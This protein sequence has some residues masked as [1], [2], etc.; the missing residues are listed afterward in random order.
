MVP[1]YSLWVVMLKHIALM[2]T[3]QL[4]RSSHVL[5]QLSS[6]NMLSHHNLKPLY[7]SNRQI[8]L[9]ILSLIRFNWQG[10]HTTTT[11]CSSPFVSSDNHSFILILSSKW[12]CHFTVDH[13]VLR[14]ELSH[15]T[16]A[17]CFHPIMEANNQTLRSHHP[18]IFIHGHCHTLM[19]FQTDFY[20]N[21]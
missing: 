11:A 14:G 8:T 18:V 16:T 6:T 21:L 1:Q 3:L 15:P 13:A 10:V 5:Y 19:L 2:A 12:T 4:L 9:S 17:L 20:G 7:K